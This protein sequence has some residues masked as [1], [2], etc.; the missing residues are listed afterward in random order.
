[1]RANLE[2]TH[3]ALFSPAR[4]CWRSSRRAGRATRPTGSSRSRRRSAWDTGTPLRELLAARDLGL[5]LDVVF[6]MAH[7]TRHAHEI[8]ARLDAVA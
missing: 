2:L 1:M 3:G 8:V 5:D 7:Y 6:D 4:R